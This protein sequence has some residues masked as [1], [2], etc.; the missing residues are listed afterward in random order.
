MDIQRSLEHA[1]ADYSALFDAKAIEVLQAHWRMVERW[2][3]RLNL[4]TMSDAETVAW[5]HY[6]DS[7]Q[8]LRV[9]GPGPWLD[10][11]SGAGFPGIPLAIARPDIHVTL[12]EPRRKRVSFLRSVVA[13]LGLPNVAVLEGRST[14]TGKTTFRGVVTRAT[15]SQHEDLRSL[16]E[17]CVEGGVVV[18]LRADASGG[19]GSRLYSYELQGQRRVMEVWSR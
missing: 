2:G 8:P 19:S 16:L 4:T 15:F 13:E 10:V 17:W 14:D 6:R 11:G 12:M 3:D 7:L 18:A 1:L 5:R 9:L